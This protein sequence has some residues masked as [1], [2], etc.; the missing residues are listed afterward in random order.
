ML[1]G[2]SN[3]QRIAAIQDLVDEIEHKLLHEKIAEDDHQHGY[4]EKR[5]RW[6]GTRTRPCEQRNGNENQQESKPD[7]REYAFV[8]ERHGGRYAGHWAGI[9]L[10]SS[11]AD[12]R[13]ATGSKPST[14]R[15]GR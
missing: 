4:D 11:S 14:M 13:W 5:Q 15:R 6:K 2:V 1:A 8:I 9:S 10:D 7:N 3:E 12:T